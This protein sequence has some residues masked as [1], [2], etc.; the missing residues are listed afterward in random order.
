MHIDRYAKVQMFIEVQWKFTLAVWY[1]P[2]GFF[3]EFIFIHRIDSREKCTRSVLLRY[4]RFLKRAFP[5]AIHTRPSSPGSV[6]MRKGNE[7]RGWR[8]PGQHLASLIANHSRCQSLRDCVYI[9][10]TG[11]HYSATVNRVV[12]VVELERA[13]PQCARSINYRSVGSWPPARNPRW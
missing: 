10:A 12:M 4:R 7:S 13:C 1:A 9:R 3:R 6:C 2:R 11:C 5:F 8:L